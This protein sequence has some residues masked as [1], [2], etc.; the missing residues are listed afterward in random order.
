MT[1]KPFI[2]NPRDSLTCKSKDISSFGWFTTHYEA[3]VVSN[4]HLNLSGEARTKFYELQKP[5]PL[6]LLISS[7]LGLNLILL[8]RKGI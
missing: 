4:L 8:T 7:L 6:I 2:N 5:K 1:A 3:R